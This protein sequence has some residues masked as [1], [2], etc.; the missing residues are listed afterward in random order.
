MSFKIKENLG[1]FALASSR[2]NSPVAPSSTNVGKVFGVITTENTPT[3]DLFEANGGFNGIGTVFYLEYGSGKNVSV[4]DLTKCKVAKPFFADNQHYPL[5]GELILLVDG[6]NPISQDVNSTAAQK[7]YLGVINLWNNNQQNAPGTGNLGKT[8]SENADIR[9]L[10]AFEGDRIYQG[11]KGNGIRFGSTVAAYSNLNE[12]SSI[13]NDGDPITILANGYVTTDSSSL[14][15]N[16]EEINKE[17]A[18]VYL[19]TSQLIPLQPNRNDSLNPIT[20]PLL[21]NQY[22]SSQVILNADRITL[23]SKKDEV[24]IFATT[25]VE[26]NTNNTINLNANGYTHINSPRINLGTNVDGTLP[27]EPVLLGG[28]THDLILD[29]CTAL[30]NVAYYLSMATATSEGSPIPAIN[31]AGTQLFNDIQNLLGDLD[32]IQSTQTFTV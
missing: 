8:F 32:N 28:K 27:T 17:Q 15:P 22:N 5:V 29:L 14:A 26:I 6:P 13:G 2:M 4:T 12:W 21:A 11:R 9:N 30:Q 10:L 18:S 16:I 19:T 24:M 25:N 3:K 31:D 1:G 23:N 20:K 7:Y